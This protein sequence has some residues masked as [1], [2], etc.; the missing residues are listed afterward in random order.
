MSSK[1]GVLLR[2]HKFFRQLKEEERQNVKERERNTMRIVGRFIQ[3]SSITFPRTSAILY[4]SYVFRL[5]VRCSSFTI[6]TDSSRV[7]SS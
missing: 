7:F 3:I 1:R 2:I 5:L 6:S 4:A